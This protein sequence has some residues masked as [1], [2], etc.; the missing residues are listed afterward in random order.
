MPRRAS[1]FT[2]ADVS[3][4]VRGAI[5]AGLQPTR[6]EIDADG[7]I[8]VFFGAAPETEADDPNGWE[9]RLRRANGWTK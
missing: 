8:V 5:N 3:R 2:Q 7:K 4:A 6:I 9:D 1:K